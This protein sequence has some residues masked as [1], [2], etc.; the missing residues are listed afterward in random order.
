MVRKQVYV[1]AR[2][3]R[4]LKRRARERDTTEAEIIREALDRA[5]QGVTR[6]NRRAASIDAAAGQKI[7]AF[8]KSL[9]TR[10]R[11]GP[12]GRTWTREALHEDRAARWTKS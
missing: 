12:A 10:R 9:A 7:I 2:H 3:D 4:M 11:K 1:L 5:A 6:P 8:M